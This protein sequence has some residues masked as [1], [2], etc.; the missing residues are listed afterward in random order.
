MATKLKLKQYRRKQP[1]YM[2][3]RLTKENG[4]EVAK[5]TKGRW[6]EA[7]H[8]LVIYNEKMG[9]LNARP[10]DY[11]IKGIH[12]RFLV[13]H[14]NDF[15]SYFEEVPDRAAQEPTTLPEPLDDGLLLSPMV[16]DT[17]NKNSRR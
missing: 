14:T 16:Q 5:W 2:G 4:A 17:L 7:R 12:G 11:I 13:Y 8:E 10:M 3:I 6:N 1:Y 9:V 15:G